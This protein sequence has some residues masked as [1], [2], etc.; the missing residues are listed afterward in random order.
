MAHRVRWLRHV[1]PT[2]EATP[3]VPAPAS[4]AVPAPTVPQLQAKA[5]ALLLLMALLV[6]GAIGYLL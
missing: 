1:R 3:S 6:S 4:A 2:T 5:T